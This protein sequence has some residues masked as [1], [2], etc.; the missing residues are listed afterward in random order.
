MSPENAN[1]FIVEDKQYWQEGLKRRLEG[2]GHKVVAS[3][4]TLTQALEA[5]KHL[6]EMGVQVATLDGNLNDYDTSGA[7]AQRV[8]REIR[9]LAP[10]VIVIG[11]SALSIPGVDVDLGKGEAFTIDKVVKDL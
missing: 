8:L 2:A 4:T 9:T 10:E 3:A 6:K 11:L 5:T 7:D 1:V